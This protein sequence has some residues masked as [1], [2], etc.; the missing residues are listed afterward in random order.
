MRRPWNIINCPIYSLVTY[1]EE[2]VNMN[3]CTYVSAVSMQ[4]KLYAI[5]IDDQTQ[6]FENLS[7]SNTVVLQI[8]HQSQIKLVNVLG[9]KSGKNYNKEAYLEKRG[10]LNQWRGYTVLKDAAAYLMLEKLNHQV[11]GDHVLF[12][13]NLKHYRTQF[14]QDILMF[15]DLIDAKIIL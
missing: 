7:S 5:A 6:T 1:T 2:G 4:P 15:Q 9:K 8:M 3:V 10:W 13:F 11:T 14:D 12:T